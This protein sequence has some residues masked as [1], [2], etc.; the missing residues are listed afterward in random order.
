M[1]GDGDLEICIVF[2]DSI[3]FKQDLLFLFAD[4]GGGV[5]GHKIGSILWTSYLHD[6]LW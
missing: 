6:S 4:G 1:E 5:G 2:V 3:P